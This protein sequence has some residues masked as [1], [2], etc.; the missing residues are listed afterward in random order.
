MPHTENSLSKKP[1]MKDGYKKNTKSC[2]AEYTYLPSLSGA[3]TLMS[4]V[5]LSNA[6]VLICKFN[7]HVSVRLQR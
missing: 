7:D 1:V 5:V 4:V 3:R 6:P 2:T